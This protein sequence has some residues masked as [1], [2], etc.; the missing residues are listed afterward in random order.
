MALGCHEVAMGSGDEL[1]PLDVQISEKDELGRYG[2]GLEIATSLEI[3]TE[4]AF[5]SFERYF[6]TTIQRSL[7]QISTKTAAEIATNL[8]VGLIAPIS[9]QIDPHRLSRETRAMD[10]AS[11]YADRLNIPH[12]AIA[13]LTTAY[14]DH[15]FVIDAE[16]AKKIL[17]LEHVRELTEPEKDLEVA[18]AR[19]MPG[20]HVPVRGPNIV[21]CLTSPNP[22]RPNVN[23]SGEESSEG[24]PRD[25]EGYSEETTRTDRG[26]C[27]PGDEANGPI[28]SSDLQGTSAT[29]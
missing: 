15:G 2:S 22:T 24:L 7:G 3:L 29:G 1:G 16:E 14:P 8:T 20:V 17:K 6:V 19:V 4:T 12:E 11:A 5:A 26:V 21:T 27:S 25:S 18:V 9:A 23:P 13:H 10:I 28:S